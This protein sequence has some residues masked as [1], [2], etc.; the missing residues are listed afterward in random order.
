MKISIFWVAEDSYM[1]QTKTKKIRIRV[2]ELRR[3]IRQV[4]LEGPSGPGV[5]SDP[6]ETKGFYPYE[7]ERGVD[8]QSFWYRSPG[9]SA[10]SDGD[11]GRPSDA[12]EYIG[13]KKKESSTEESG[14]TTPEPAVATPT[15]KAEK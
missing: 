2:S 6:T 8:V 9:R 3:L 13:L 10:G 14:T 1:T 4:L 7:M 11:P 12:A 5:T 15:P